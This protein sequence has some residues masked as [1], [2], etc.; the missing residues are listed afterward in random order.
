MYVLNTMLFEGT[1]HSG[2]WVFDISWG[3][4]RAGSDPNPS[5]RVERPV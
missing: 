1:L 3:T 2:C 5:R 4:F